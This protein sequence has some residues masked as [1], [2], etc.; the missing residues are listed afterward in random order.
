LQAQHKGLNEFLNSLVVETDPRNPN[1]TGPR[2][3]INYRHRYEVDKYYEMPASMQG[4]LPLFMQAL[5][6]QK[7]HTFK[8][9]VTHD[10]RSG[11]IL[12]KI[13]KARVADLDLYMPSCPLDCRLSVNIEMP[14]EDDPSEFAHMAGRTGQG[15]H[16]PDRVKDRLSYAQGPYQ[17]D[18]TQVTT[19]SIGPNVRPTHLARR[20]STTNTN[21]VSSPRWRRSTNSR[22]S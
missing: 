4:R 20:V 13:V 22:L 19:E 12:A 6:P 16:P 14:W 3:Q 18:L 5:I 8:V 17:V 10:Q 7:R 15:L 1:R 9:R 2:V 11:D 21:I